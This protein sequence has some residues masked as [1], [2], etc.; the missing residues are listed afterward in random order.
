MEPDAN[1]MQKFIEMELNKDNRTKLD[2]RVFNRETKEFYEPTPEMMLHAAGNAFF[3]INGE[4]IPVDK[5]GKRH[6]LRLRQGCMSQMENA[7]DN[8]VYVSVVAS[9]ADSGCDNGVANANSEFLPV[10]DKEL[11][12]SVL[13]RKYKV[14]IPADHGNC[15]RMAETADVSHILGAQKRHLI[16]GE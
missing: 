1:S 6:I 14:E 15:A 13:L 9:S 11:V 3:L 2:F 7:S 4:E 8:F 10:N 12:S 16:P 5:L